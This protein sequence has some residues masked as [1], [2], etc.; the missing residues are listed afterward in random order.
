MLR[1]GYDEIIERIKKE[2]GLSDIEIKGKIDK[3]LSD[4]AGLIS[5]EGAAHIVANELG[6]KLFDKAMME[7]VKIK[8]LLIGMRKVG[9][10]GKVTSVFSVNSF[11]KD[12]KERKVGSFMAGDETGRVRI[13]VW[14][15]KHI[16]EMEEGNIKE[17]VIVKVENAYVK[18][19]NGFKEIH[20]NGNSILSVNPE[21]IK[22]EKVSDVKAANIFRKKINELKEKETNVSLIGT[23]VQLFQPRFFEVCSECGKKALLENGSYNCEQHGI[24]SV[25]SVP[26]LNFVM[27]D[28]SGVIRTVAFRD[29]ACRI[30]KM[31]EEKVLELKDNAKFEEHKLNIEGNQYVVDG[32]TSK[33]QMFERVEF[34]ANNVKEVTPEILMQEL[35]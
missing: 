22:I 33:N 5:K 26:V 7:K 28:G 25:K 3:K 1:V 17:D 13:V 8:D 18:E 2:K 30:L 20:L 9:I 10:N 24:V 14:D 12:G 21:V 27:D 16:K 23:L 29:N 15:E 34:V 32:R 31:D 6:I 19:N 4:L 35:G 11:I